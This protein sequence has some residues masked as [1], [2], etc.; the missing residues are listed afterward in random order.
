MI[1]IDVVQAR[2]VTNPSADPMHLLKVR[3]VN[4]G[5]PIL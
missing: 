1:R 2:N 4:Q 3:K 5:Q